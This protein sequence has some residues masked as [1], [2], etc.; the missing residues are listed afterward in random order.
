[1]P[2]PTPHITNIAL[3]S[4]VPLDAT[5]RHSIYFASEGAQHAYFAGKVVSGLSWSDC[6]YHREQDSI[7]VNATIDACEGVNYVMFQ[8]TAYGNKWFYAFVTDHKYINANCTE[9]IIKLDVLQ[10]WYFDYE[11]LPCFIERC[12]TTTDHIGDN[13]VPEPLE[14]G[15]YIIYNA[16]DLVQAQM[17]DIYMWTTFDPSNVNVASGGDISTGIFSALA[18]TRIG[19]VSLNSG[20]N[21]PSWVVDPRPTIKDLIDNHAD[22]VDGLVALTMSPEITLP[23]TQPFTLR[24][25]NIDGYTPRNKKLFTSPYNVVGLV[26]TDGNTN[27]LRPEYF[28]RGSNPQTRWNDGDTV[29]FYVTSDKNINETIIVAP[30]NYRTR[31][32]SMLASAKRTANYVTLSGMPQCAWVS[33]AFKTFLAQNSSNNALTLAIGVGKVAAGAL[34]I[35][36]S[37]GAA[38]SLAGPIA[39]SGAADIAR[40]LGLTLGLDDHARVA[41]IQHGNITGTAAMALDAKTVWAYNMCIHADYAERIDDYFDMF[42]YAQNKIGA[43]NTHARPHWSYIKTR[44]ALAR[45]SGSGAPAGALAEIQ[46]IYDTGVTFW[47]S[48]DEVG[49][50]SLD[51]RV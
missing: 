48:G 16:A 4:G 6:M 28:Q 5:Y 45:P 24:A 17:W 33:D 13:I 43:I 21:S 12:H 39:L 51:N 27:I 25:T 36:G 7:H 23:V 47:A 18:K 38:A 46:S 34:G 32:G 35:L 44:G 41:P 29:N 30:E 20:F 49:D 19:R 42:G 2:F 40:V 8:N 10:T 22:K 1:M 3:L 37:E 50:Y 31:G 9:L 11:I 26:S 14:Y 15:E